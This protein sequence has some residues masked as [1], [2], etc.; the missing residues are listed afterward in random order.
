[1]TRLPGVRRGTDAI[2]DAFALAAS[3]RRCALITY[4]TAGYPTPSESASLIHALQMGGS[5][6]IELGVPFSDPVADGPA[7][8]R[9]SQ[10]ALRAGVTP[11]YCLNLV[12][13]L[14]EQG[15]TVPL[16]LMGYYNLIHSHGLAR[17]ARDCAASGVDG[18]IVPDLPPEEAG[19]LREACSPEG[20]AVILLVAPTSG[21]SRISRIASMSQGFLYVVSRLG[22]TGAEVTV[23]AELE[24]RLALV[25]RY[26]KIPIAVGFGISRPEQVRAL[27]P[28][29]DGLIV[30]SAVVERAD[31]GPE[32]LRSYVSSLAAVLGS[33][34]PS[35]SPDMDVMPT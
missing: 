30:G 32:A 28:L 24:A 17:Y 8:Q 12:R 19:S 23:G 29:V 9:A 15:I 20:L 25:R 26:A 4:I 16:I 18:L 10:A 7:I 5:D 14:R 27:A 1:M 13:D 2:A 22:I 11:E 21:E 6:I 34:P 31:R 3:E 35:A 33:R